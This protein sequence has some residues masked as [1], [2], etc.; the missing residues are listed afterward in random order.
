MFLLKKIYVTLL[1]PL[2][3]VYI[4]KETTFR[5]RGFHLTVLPGIFHPQFF[6]ST[7]FFFSFLDRQ[8]LKGKYCLEIGCGAG[9]LS[10]LMLRKGGHVTAVDI[11]A[12]AVQNTELNYRK[13]K[14][15]FSEPLQ[16]LQSDLFAHPALSR[17]EVV[18]VNPPYFFAE[19]TK[20]SQHAWFCGENGQ[21]FQRLF[22]GIGTH[23]SPGASVYMVLAE[24][25]DISRIGQIAG[26]NGFE[27]EL[28]VKK[29]I[30][31]ENNF[32]F[33]INPVKI[34]A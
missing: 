26:N 15:Q 14:E 33:K 6:F 16:L 19:V 12:A 13:N 5:F 27:L 23:L 18:I 22:S 32:I 4:R 17:Y 2:I 1:Y 11:Q 9:L 29:R 20:E 30:W 10:L 34:A 8:T 31:W 3:A 7:R 21:Y 24:N 25:C 28:L